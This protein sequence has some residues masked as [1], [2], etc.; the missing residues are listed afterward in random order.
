[1]PRDL[2]AVDVENLT[3]HKGCV[4]EVEH[5][6][7][8]VFDFADPVERMEGGERAEG[9]RF[10]HRCPDDARRDRVHADAAGGVFYGEAAGRSIKAALG[11]RR[12][13]RGNA[14]IRI[15]NQRCCDL[16]NVTAALFFHYPQG[17]LGHEEEAVEIGLQILT[18]LFL[19]V[20][21]EGAGRKNARIVDQR[22]QAAEFGDGLFNGALAGCR[23]A[24]IA[25]DS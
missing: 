4:L 25:R 22:I 17:V 2:A 8:D 10:M 19:G 3:R 24:N 21:G 23:I 12:Q 9:L 5:T 20:A 15:I 16:H 7:D 13:N 14:G 18:I 1:M 6:M 11:N